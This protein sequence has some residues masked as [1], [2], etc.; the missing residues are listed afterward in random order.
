M[1]KGY[2]SGVGLLSLQLMCRIPVCRVE[3]VQKLWIH[4]LGPDCICT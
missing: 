2:D 4:P 1:P 3:L